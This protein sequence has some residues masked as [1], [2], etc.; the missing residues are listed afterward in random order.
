MRKDFQATVSEALLN[1][2]NL[3]L[4]LGDIGVFGFRDVMS[5]LPQR[6]L[7]MGILEQAMTSFAAGVAKSGAIPIVHSIAPFMIERPFEQLK[8]DFGYQKLVGKFVSVGGSF[9]YSALGVTHH[10]PGD[11]SLIGA[12]PGFEIFLPNSGKSLRAQLER[13]LLTPQ[14]SYFR[15]SEE[16]NVRSPDKS[17]NFGISVFA[18][19]RET[20]V[21]FI[22]SS[23]I[24]GLE[25]CEGVDVG[26]MSIEALNP[27]TA[28]ALASILDSEQTS[29][30]IF[31]EP[32]YEGSTYHFVSSLQ[33]QFQMRFVGVPREF[34]HTYGSRGELLEDN[35]MDS[36]S[37]RQRISALV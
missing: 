6:V 28:S 7:N 12:I 36:K 16:E 32:Y 4:L 14:N 21:I 8:V 22:G 31:V 13:N 25:A 20:V 29:K 24:Q 27:G 9:D 17:H 1:H 2:E 23:I 15:L 18:E 35:L 33:A 11:V 26:V 37:L 34:C 3:V 5:K 10:C 19:P 30:I